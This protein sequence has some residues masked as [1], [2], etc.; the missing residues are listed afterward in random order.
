MDA[1]ITAAARALAA[2][3]PLGALDRVALRDD[4][5]ALALRGIA[6]AQL[7]DF[8]RARTLL[9]S[10][11][12]AFSPRQTLARARCVVAEA[13]IA[14]AARDLG[15]PDKPLEAA[16]AVLEQQGDWAN[17]AHA[18]FV[19]IRRLSL[20][21]ALDQAEAQLNEIDPTRLPASLQAIHG[22]A[23][24]GLAIR[25]LDIATAHS[26]LTHA[27][28]A[29]HQAHIPALSAEVQDA[30][31][32]LDTPAARITGP[33]DERLL[34]LEQIQ[35]LLDSPM[36]V[37]DDRRQLLQDA[38]KQVSLAGRP[39]LMALLRSLGE[40]WPAAVDR[41]T[42][43]ARAFN[44]KLSDESHRARL[45]VEIGR[46]RVL[47][48]PL[49]EVSATAD[50]YALIARGQPG[51]A[52]LAWPQDTH[53]GDVLALL[54]DGQAWSSSALALALGISQRSVQRALESLAS[55]GKV[56]AFGRGRAARWLIPPLPGFA[57]A[58]LLTP[59]LPSD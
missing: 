33:G 46:L 16:R 26:A 12:R 17:A 9:R 22:L 48:K 44:L 53:Y 20:L 11:A 10:A 13:E 2:G 29:A 54:M 27:S 36:L 6:M 31:Q 38:H 56:Q 55:A 50:G 32:V 40:A 52:V 7:G 28:D 15:Q 45:R 4:P 42:L 35:A 37:I 34:L 18:R 39:V 30:W 49:A 43:I 21:G 24:A 58:L 57:T 23:R 59:T 47:L 14:F 8:A 3:D 51:V 41:A 19:A 5:P 25:K 1:L